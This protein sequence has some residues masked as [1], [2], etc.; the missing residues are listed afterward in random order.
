MTSRLDPNK[1]T[2]LS[3]DFSEVRRELRESNNDIDLKSYKVH[4]YCR[5]S[6]IFKGKEISDP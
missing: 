4:L 5:T 6:K 2:E 3:D 1:Y